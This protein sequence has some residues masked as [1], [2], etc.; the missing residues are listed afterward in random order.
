M[1]ERGYAIVRG[2]TACTSSEDETS[3]AVAAWYPGQAAVPNHARWRA[4]SFQAWPHSPKPLSVSSRRDAGK[5]LEQSAKRRRI[6]VPAL[7][8]DFFDGIVGRLQRLLRL[9]DS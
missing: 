9:L 3:A 5:A 1:T 2:F 6:F 8:R 7:L 4:V